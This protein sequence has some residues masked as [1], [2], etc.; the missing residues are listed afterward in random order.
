MEGWKSIGKQTRD[1]GEM[2]EVEGGE[3]EIEREAQAE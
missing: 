1:D 3:T 2:E